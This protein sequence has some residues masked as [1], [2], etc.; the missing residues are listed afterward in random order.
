MGNTVS[1]TEEV[2]AS[3]VED[4]VGIWEGRFMG[5]VAY[6]QFE[7]DGTLT[8][9][10]QVEWL[11]DPSL[12]KYSGRYWF[13]GGVLKITEPLA[14]AHGYG[15]GAYEVWVRKREGTAVHLSFHDRGDP[16]SKRRYDWCQGMTG[17]EP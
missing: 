3:K 7:V 8:C 5:S 10:M 2:L 9:A 11:H 6:R 14:E 16:D 1:H 15:P 17:V 12:L 4:L 13:E